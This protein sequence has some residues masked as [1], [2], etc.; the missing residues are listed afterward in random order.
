M[1]PEPIFQTET[2]ERQKRI[3]WRIVCEACGDTFPAV[4]RDARYCS[5]ACKL[6]AHRAKKADSE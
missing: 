2:V 5:N 1:D 3:G 6:R 4:R